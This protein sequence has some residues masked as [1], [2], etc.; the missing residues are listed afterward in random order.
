MKDFFFD[1]HFF[2]ILSSGRS[3]EDNLDP[4]L[5]PF[6]LEYNGASVAAI[7]NN[8]KHIVS[9]IDKMANTG[10]VR[11]T[12]SRTL[13]GV[14][15]QTEF[16]LLNARLSEKADNLELAE[17]QLWRLFAQYQGT[18][19]NGTIDYPGSFNIRDTADEI[20]QLQV[21]RSAA[22]NPKVFNLI[23]GRIAEWL[24]EEE[25]IVFA[26]DMA[27]VAVGLPA[28]PV[29]EPHIMTDPATGQEYIARTLQEHLDYVALGYVHDDDNN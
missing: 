1:N 22:T 10:A 21:A 17:E 9:A 28:Q 23:D 13:S 18:V 5:K 24:G 6:I 4:G 27:T 15:M 14:A 2:K 7:I 20:T 3:L 16:S 19:W 25:D 26:Q 8:I 12:E 11:A 29:F